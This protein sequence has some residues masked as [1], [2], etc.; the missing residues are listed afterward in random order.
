MPEELITKP[1]TPRD[2]L[3]Y[4]WGEPI[5]APIYLFMLP[6]SKTIWLVNLEHVNRTLSA[7]EDCDI[8]TGAGLAPLGNVSKSDKRVKQDEVEGIAGLWADID[9]AHPA[10]KSR[11]TYAPSQEAILELL[12]E[13]P[14][15]PTLLVNSGHGIQ[16]W[17]L[18]DHAWIFAD[19]EE[20][21]QARALSQWW[22]SQIAEL[23]A[24]RGWHVDAVQNLDRV[25]RVPGTWNHKI[26]GEPKKV[27]VIENGGTRYAREEF[28]DRMPSDFQPKVTIHRA[29]VTGDTVGGDKL[30]LDPGA[31]PPVMKLSVLI[32]ED[33]KF[34][35]SWKGH[36][37]DWDPGADHS[38]SAYDMSLASIAIKYGWT[39]QEVCDLLIA[40]RR[41]M[42]QDLKLREQYY[43]STIDKAKLPMAQAKGEER[44]N[45]LLDVP[46]EWTLEQRR[47][48]LQGLSLMMGTR[49]TII[50]IYKFPGERPTYALETD[51]G[52]VRLG[53]IDGLF[54]P[55]RF[56]KKVAAETG[57]VLNIKKYRKKWDVFVQLM[58]DASEV[59]EM[60]DLQNALTECTA[61]I[62][63]F[64]ADQDIDEDWEA[65][66]VEKRPF[67]YKDGGIYISIPG[68]LA[69]SQYRPHINTTAHDLAERF[70][71][72]GAVHKQVDVQVEGSK[73]TSAQAWRLPP[74][75]HE[76]LLG[77][78][79][80]PDEGD[81]AP[82]EGGSQ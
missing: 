43:A 60:G 81:S 46:T 23:F 2:F 26:A 63:E 78:D 77:N 16:A 75:W 15:E 42:N 14:L 71:G 64:T 54:S 65:A 44:I 55:D 56:A 21:W 49:L 4:L 22:A 68:M 33:E 69:W 79:M 53:G 19:R 41:K 72:I 59:Q 57:V 32:E 58:L 36:R 30:V 9:F 10:H 70:R 34:L 13:L 52:P 12:E 80:V 62:V 7:Y 24:G 8:Y 3:V 37:P 5:P 18:F 74:S 29:G 20:H 38:A 35:A 45:E 66:A 17:W 48:A 51:H 27:E 25:M 39:D 73:R 1:E 76:M 40:K 61:W 50:G 31:E 11:K 28:L 6:I 67:L 82:G 47:E